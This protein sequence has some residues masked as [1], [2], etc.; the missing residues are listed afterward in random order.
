MFVRARLPRTTMKG[1]LTVPQQAVTGAGDGTPQVSVVG[2]QD[3][4]HLRRVTLGPLVEP[5]MSSSRGCARA[6][7]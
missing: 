5:A 6:K 7:P 3:R 1:A 2:R 4:V